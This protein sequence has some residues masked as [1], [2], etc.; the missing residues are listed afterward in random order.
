MFSDMDYDIRILFDVP[1]PIIA[2]P[3]SNGWIFIDQNTKQ[4]VNEL[5]II[6][7]LLLVLIY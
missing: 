6:F 2:Q 7:F 5:T 4:Q 3:K 1:D